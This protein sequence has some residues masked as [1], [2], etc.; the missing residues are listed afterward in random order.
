MKGLRREGENTKMVASKAAATGAIT[1]L[2]E[3][4]FK[5]C[6][7]ISILYCFSN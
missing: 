1:A 5:L 3:Y 4:F 7:F 6:W 2:V